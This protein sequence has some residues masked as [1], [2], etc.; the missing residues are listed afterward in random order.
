MKIPDMYHPKYGDLSYSDDDLTQ[1][2]LDAIDELEDITET[3]EDGLF[4]SGTSGKVCK[5]LYCKKCGGTEF[6]VGQG[7]YRTQVKCVKCQYEVC[8]H[9]G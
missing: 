3:K 7:F 2:Q 6:H 5:T 8:I 1:E 4:H 9:D